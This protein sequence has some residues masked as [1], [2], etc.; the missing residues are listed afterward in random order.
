MLIIK[1]YHKL[2]QIN[3]SVRQSHIFLHNDGIRPYMYITIHIC[4]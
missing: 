2:T 3:Y 4:G 1:F